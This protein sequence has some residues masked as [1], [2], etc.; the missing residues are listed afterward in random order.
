[1]ICKKGGIEAGLKEIKGNKN[2]K[3]N[4]IKHKLY[5]MVNTFNTFKDNKSVVTLLQTLL[6]RK[7][8]DM[9]CHFIA[10][11]LCN[12]SNCVGLNYS[13]C[14]GSNGELRITRLID[15]LVNLI[16]SCGWPD[17][18]DNLNEEETKENRNKTE[19]TINN[20]SDEEIEILCRKT[21]LK[22]LECV[23]LQTITNI[24]DYCEFVSKLFKARSINNH[25]HLVTQIRNNFSDFLSTRY[26]LLD[27]KHG[28]TMKSESCG[29]IFAAIKYI[30]VV[31]TRAKVK[32]GL[33]TKIGKFLMVKKI[34]IVIIWLKCC[35][36][37]NILC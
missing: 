6:N 34:R 12:K 3:P 33:L 30:C 23:T 2:N 28:N 1:M 10:T 8:Y 29:S 25:D 17:C 19:A 37:G 21:I 35:V 9:A 15:V 27:C 16:D 5:Y 14:D 31:E 26:Q 13:S 20:E 24:A 36:N 7:E 11:K 22:L 32:V 18:K 4:E